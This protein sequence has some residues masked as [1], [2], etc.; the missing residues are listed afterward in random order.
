MSILPAKVH[1]SFHTPIQS[2]LTTI[3]GLSKKKNLY[4]SDNS[5][6]NSVKVTVRKSLATTNADTEI[7]S[8]KASMNKQKL[9]RPS[10]YLFENIEKT[11]EDA[12]GNFIIKGKKDHKVSFKDNVSNENIAEVILV[13]NYNSTKTNSNDECICKCS[14]GCSIL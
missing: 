11:R 9:K 12:Y 1:V 3:L 14:G 7:C 2:D 13:E 5:L 10:F 4:L 8:T 6:I